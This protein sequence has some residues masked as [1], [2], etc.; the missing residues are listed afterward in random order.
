MMW[1]GYRGAVIDL[2]KVGQ[3]NTLVPDWLDIAPG[4]IAK[5][6]AR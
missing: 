3:Y 4:E 1:D 6:S 5:H 2:H